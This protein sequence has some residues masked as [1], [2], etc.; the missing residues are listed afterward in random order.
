M[1][2]PPYYDTP[3]R[4]PDDFPRPKRRPNCQVN[5]F[6]HLEGEDIRNAVGVGWSKEP[7]VEP[8]LLDIFG[9][10]YEVVGLPGAKECPLPEDLRIRP[11]RHA[12]SR[13]KTSAYCDA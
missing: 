10:L 2:H 7:I 1:I 5:E 13:A 12:K 3:P 4:M 8:I 6:I 9:D 11:P